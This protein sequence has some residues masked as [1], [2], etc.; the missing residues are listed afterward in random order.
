MLRRPTALAFSTLLLAGTALAQAPA[1]RP[2]QQQRP[3]QAQATPTPGAVSQPD[4][5]TATY[6]DW[7]MRCQQSV[8]ARVCEIVQ[9]LEQ[10]GQRGPI[11]LVAIGRPVKSEPIKLVIQVPP[12]LALGDKASVRVVVAEKDEAVAVFQR[13]L[14]GGC[15][16]EASLSDDVFKRWRGLSE[17]GQMRYL[18]AGKRE[19]TLPLSFRGFPAA[20]EA[21]L[22]E[23]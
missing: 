10:Q 21:L 23:P 15:F 19:I 9:T 17:A 11:A 5:T 18:D 8:A 2:A 6:G 1:Q 13:C 14:P 4:N 12:N 20:A 22:R 16:A 7:V 3:A